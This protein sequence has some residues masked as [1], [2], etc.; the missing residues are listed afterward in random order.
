L[1][2]SRAADR[3]TLSWPTNAL[4]FDLQSSSDLS[5]ANWLKV[6][7]PAA[8]SGEQFTI[9]NDLAGRSKFFPAESVNLGALSAAS[10]FSAFL[11]ESLRLCV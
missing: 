5:P 9:T 8:I 4:G 7:N 3:V 6:T 1:T 2:I 11:G 10:L